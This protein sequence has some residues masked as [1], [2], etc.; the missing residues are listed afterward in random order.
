[1]IE[2]PKQATKEVLHHATSGLDQCVTTK[3][4]AQK[5]AQRSYMF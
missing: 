2:V 1:M 5:L 4:S 3:L